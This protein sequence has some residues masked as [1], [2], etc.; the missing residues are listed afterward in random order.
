MRSE[1]VVERHPREHAEQ[2]RTGRVHDHGA[3]GQGVAATQCDVMDQQR[4]YDGA[5]AAGTGHKQRDA[6]RRRGRA[7]DRGEPPAQVV[8]GYDERQT[9]DHR[10]GHVGQARRDVAVLGQKRGIDS[11][12]R[13]R[14]PAAQEAHHE[15]RAGHRDA[16]GQVLGERDQQSDGEGAGQ[17]DQQRDPG[18]RPRPDRVMRVEEVSGHG[19]QGPA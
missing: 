19:A 4:A 5:E 18:E 2:E 11:Q 14:G 10:G 9:A 6:E 13:V 15:Q 1:A 17:V 7:H 12:G 3:D 8:A 16:M